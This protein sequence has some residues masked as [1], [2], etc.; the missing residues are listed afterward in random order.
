MKSNSRLLAALRLA[1]PALGLLGA[2]AAHATWEY[3]P[4]LSM[5]VET[6]NNVLVD[7]DAKESASRTA[8]DLSVTLT[9]FT[10]RGEVQIQ[11]RI[12][13]D[14]YANSEHKPLETEDRYLD[15]SGNYTW[16]KVGASFRTSYSNVS[17]LRAEFANAVPSDPDIDDPIDVDTG[18]LTPL[19]EKREYL[20]NRANVE[21]QLSQRS[22]IGVE[23]RRADVSYSQQSIAR[24]FRS[25][26]DDT[27]VALRLTRRSDERNR[28]SAQVFASDFSAKSTANETKSVGVAGSFT[29]PLTQTLT[30]DLSAGVQRSD[31]RYRA[32]GTGEI[33][34]NADTNYTFGVGFRKLGERS[35]VNVTL[36]RALDPNSAGHVVVRDQLR[37]FLQ[38][39][40][41]PRLA[42]EF[43]VRWFSY[44]AIDSA[45][46]FDD[47]TFTRFEMAFDYALK[48][49]L[50]LSFGLDSMRQKYLGEGTAT[51]NFL[52]VGVSYRGLSQR[53]LLR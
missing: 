10:Q 18:R 38:R 19:N 17:T 48:R 1:A 4:N 27:A 32:P 41:T 29:R 5:F 47:R 6:T 9:N 36:N 28:I 3:L 15:L 13:S 20:A 22:S 26:F 21:F 39:Q 34:D 14:Y 40:I 24:D 16:Q 37:A 2:G 53:E 11:P 23:L 50:F 44:E 33:V 31:F 49:T 52:F 43:G 8:L 46:A 7:P 42:G 12:T 35:I 51:A 30:L 25:D 45:R